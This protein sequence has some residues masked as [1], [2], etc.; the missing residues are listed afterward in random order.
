[1]SLFLEVVNSC[2]SNPCFNGGTCVNGLDRYDCL[3]TSS[4][5]GVHCENGMMKLFFKN[6]LIEKLLSFIEY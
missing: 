4:Y 3:C 1:M 5:N 6:K 2:A